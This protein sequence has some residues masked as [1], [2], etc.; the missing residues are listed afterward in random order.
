MIEKACRNPSEWSVG[1][2][3]KIRYF[4]CLFG[5]TFNDFTAIWFYLRSR[6]GNPEKPCI[7]LGYMEEH[8]PEYRLALS[9]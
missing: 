2:S 9:I 5:K 8:F 3:E 4:H 6:L 1:A 7:D